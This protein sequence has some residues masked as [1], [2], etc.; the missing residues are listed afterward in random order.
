[1]E[2]KTSRAEVLAGQLP[3]IIGYSVGFVLLIVGRI[4]ILSLEAVLGLMFRF[5]VRPSLAYPWGLSWYSVIDII[6]MTIVLFAVLGWGRRLLGILASI[7]PE[8][9]AMASLADLISILGAVVLGYFAYDDLIVPPL[10]SQRVAWAYNLVFTVILVGILA[11][12]GVTIVRMV[13]RAR[14]AGVALRTVS[15]VPPSVPRANLPSRCAKCE[16]PLS[17]GNRY[18]SRCGAPVEETTSR[19]T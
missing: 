4:I 11:V 10:A 6:L 13:V 15:S 1:M 2:S 12:A 18:C 7:F 3:A 17:S 19:E 8:L 14:K 5:L 16:A 9:P